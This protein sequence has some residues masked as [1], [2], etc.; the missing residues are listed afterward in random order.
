MTITALKISEDLIPLSELKAQAGEIVRRINDN[1]R[2]AVVTR[3][4][5]GVAVLVPVELYERYQAALETAEL[6]LAVAEAEA[7]FAAGRVVPVDEV[8]ARLAARF[9]DD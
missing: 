3:H 4:G 9:A 6:Q 5:R 8:R 1:Q 2:P 7:D